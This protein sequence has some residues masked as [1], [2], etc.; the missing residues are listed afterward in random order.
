VVTNNIK[1][2]Y[3]ST[4]CG[5]VCENILRALPDWFGIEDSL[6]QYVKDADIMPTMLAKDEDDV[7]GFITIK[8][9][10]PESADIHC[11]G[12][13]P[14][15][16]RKGIGKLL[17]KELENYLKDEGVKILQVKTV[18][19]DRDCGAYAKTRDFYRAVGFFPLEVFSNWWDD[20]NPCLLL[21]K[22]IWVN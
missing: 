2:Q 20:A 14:K 6:V 12:I 22:Q 3:P 7:I 21:V 5:Q 10:F 9:H 15:Y 13:L 4:S 11:M 1:I 19:A 8:K 17:I 18:S 16:H